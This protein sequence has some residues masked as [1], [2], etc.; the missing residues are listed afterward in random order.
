MAGRGPWFLCLVVAGTAMVICF[1]VSV[2]DLAGLG[3]ET[4]AALVDLSLE[5]FL[6]LLVLCT[7]TLENYVLLLSFV[8]LFV[9]S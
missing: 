6:S 1:R 8:Y 7:F 2:V 3:A 5:K 9:S 4:G